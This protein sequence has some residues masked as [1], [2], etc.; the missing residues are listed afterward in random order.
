LVT[1]DVKYHEAREAEE[2]GLAL[3][4]AGHFA[5]ELPM[6]WGLTELLGGELAKKG[7]AAEIT[8]FEGE[9]EPFRFI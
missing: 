4:D 7:Y 6:V 1:G 8:A 3:V 9:R 5:T 2:L